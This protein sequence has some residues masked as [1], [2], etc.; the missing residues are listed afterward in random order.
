M[1][2][3][4]RSVRTAHKFVRIKIQSRNLLSPTIAL[5]NRSNKVIRASPL[6]SPVVKFSTMSPL[7]SGVAPLPP[8]RDYDP[9]I[10]DIA[11]YVHNTSIESDLAVGYSNNL[12]EE[13]RLQTDA[14]SLIRRG[15]FS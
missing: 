9:E 3:I 5:K 10:K 15:S 6:R 14:Y 8:A 1:S 11:S 7:Q 12:N 2:A 13:Y 4:N